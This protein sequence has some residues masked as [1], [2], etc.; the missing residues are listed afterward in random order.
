MVR[1]IGFGGVVV[2]LGLTACGAVSQ[3]W[4]GP[5][6]EVRCGYMGTAANVYMVM[7]FA[8]GDTASSPP[9]TPA[10]LASEPGYQAIMRQPN[11]SSAARVAESYGWSCTIST[12]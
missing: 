10:G 2:M 9:A 12:P 1:R 4:S 11:P 3:G 7:H 5:V 8:A 6:T